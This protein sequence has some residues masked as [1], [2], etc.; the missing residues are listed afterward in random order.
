MLFEEKA[1]VE[2]AHE[3]TNDSVFGQGQIDAMSWRN[4]HK[5]VWKNGNW[6]QKLQNVLWRPYWWLKR[7]A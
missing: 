3:T 6:W 5:F 7:R 4:A 1:V 2:H